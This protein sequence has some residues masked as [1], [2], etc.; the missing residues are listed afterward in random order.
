MVTLAALSDINPYRLYFTDSRLWTPYVQEIAR[1]HGL[2]QGRLV[3]AGLAGTFPTFIVDQACVVKLFGELFDGEKSFTAEKNTNE[4]LAQTGSWPVPALIASGRLDPSGTG[5][6]WPYLIFEYIPG[7]SLGEQSATVSHENRIVLAGEVGRFCR[8][9]HDLPLPH[10]GA[11]LPSWDLYIDFLTE[12]RAH[13]AA[14]QASWGHLPERLVSQIDA[15]LPP[16]EA[17]IPPGKPPHLIHADLTRDHLLGRI[18]HGRWETTGIIDFGDA[19]VGDI[20]YEIVALH[21][22]L[23]AGDKRLL[24]AFVQSYG[25]DGWLSEDFPRKAMAI[26]LMHQ[27]D[28][29]ALLDQN[30][31]QAIEA[32]TLNDLAELI[33]GNGP[34]N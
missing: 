24:A 5:W 12:R 28:V 15:F 32:A 11:F 31:P 3:R 33:W 23:F 30:L 18:D 1:R 7:I 27:F 25:V 21:L 13:C 19:R 10:G 34:G 14:D 20:Y 9:L 26:T 2:G 22:D 6:P 8:R 17:L 29:L 16:V 4:F